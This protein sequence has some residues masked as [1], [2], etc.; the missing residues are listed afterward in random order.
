[1]DAARQETGAAAPSPALLDT[2]AT[3]FAESGLD[4][5]G[6]AAPPGADQEGFDPAAI[7]AASGGGAA[8]PATQLLGI[9][10]TGSGLFLSPLRQLALWEMK[11]RGREF[12]ENGANELL[13]RLQ[14]AAPRARFPLMGHS[15][16]CIVA[17]ATVAGPAG[18]PDLPR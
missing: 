18:E 1:L 9:G 15:F 17:S 16:G 12:G 8:K 2:Y 4:A 5:G 14:I 11:D 7:I 13:A 3:L 10:D 6:S